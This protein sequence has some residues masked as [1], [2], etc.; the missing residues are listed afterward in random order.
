MHT[1]MAVSSAGREASMGQHRL[2]LVNISIYLDKF[3]LAGYKQ[4]AEMLYLSNIRTQEENKARIASTN[5]FKTWRAGTV[6]Q[7]RPGT[8]FISAFILNGDVILN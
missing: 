3:M 4:T 5:Y 6:E 7:A 1:I 8:Q 2:S